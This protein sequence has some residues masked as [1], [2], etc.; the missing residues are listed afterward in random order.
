[1]WILRLQIR[2]GPD[3]I[4]FEVSGVLNWILPVQICYQRKLY[5]SIQTFRKT[6]NQSEFYIVTGDWDNSVDEGTEQQFNLS[7]IHFYPKYEGKFL[8]F[9]A[10]NF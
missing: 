3:R 6:K 10:V 1:M 2:V 9:L 7:R 4:N 8:A 5:I